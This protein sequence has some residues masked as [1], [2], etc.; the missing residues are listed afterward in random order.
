MPTYFDAFTRF[1]P[2]PRQ[3]PAARWSLDHLVEEMRFCSISG[4]L[5]THSAQ[6]HYDAMLENR[7]LIDRIKGHDFLFPIWC[8]FPHWT[9]EMPEPGDLVKEMADRNVRAVMLNP[10]ANAWSLTSRTSRPLLESLEKHGIVAMIDATEADFDKLEQVCS[11]HVELAVVAR[12]VRWASCHAAVPLLLNYK[13]FHITLDHFQ[14]NMA[15]EWLVA[16]GC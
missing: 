4:A 8:A 5:V 9:G 14:V 16:Q 10:G 7:R 12:H 6:W 3:H 13:N 15:P 2:R 11:E 1:G